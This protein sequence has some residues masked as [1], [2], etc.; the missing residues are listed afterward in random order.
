MKLVKKSYWYISLKLSDLEGSEVVLKGNRYTFKG[1]TLTNSLSLL[2][3]DPLCK[4]I[5]QKY[6]KM[7]S[8]EIFTQSAKH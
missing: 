7:W 6:F 8:A 2:K 4:E 5:F 3:R 1:V